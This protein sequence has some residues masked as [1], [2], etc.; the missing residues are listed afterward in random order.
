VISP[1][2]KNQ[3]TGQNITQSKEASASRFSRDCN[4]AHSL[5]P[6]LTNDPSIIAILAE[7]SIP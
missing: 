4:I 2:L 6:G 1:I 7:I 3:K 5:P